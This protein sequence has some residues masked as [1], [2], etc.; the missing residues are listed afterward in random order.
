MFSLPGTCPYYLNLPT[1]GRFTSPN[2]PSN[3]GNND[4]CTLLIEAPP[5]QYIYLKFVSFNLESRYDFVEIF[6]GSWVGSRRIVKASGTQA[7]QDIY[8]SGR[9][10]FARF[11]SDGSF[12]RRGFLATY[13]GVSYSKRNTCFIFWQK[14]LF[15]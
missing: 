7:P 2:Y 15:K 3:Y 6:D 11:R 12:V 8:S 5:G 13:H 9:F 14:R 10:L 4:Y 1:G